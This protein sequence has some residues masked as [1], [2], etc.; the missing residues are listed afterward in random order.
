M[1]FIFASGAE[2]SNS[3]KSGAARINEI[4]SMARR[5]VSFPHSLSHTHFLALR[6]NSNLPTSNIPSDITDVLW[7]SFQI[8]L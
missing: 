8:K 6:L 2:F 1:P 4:F 5:N 3:E 7:D